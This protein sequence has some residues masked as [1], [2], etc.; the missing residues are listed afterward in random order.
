MLTVLSNTIYDSISYKALSGVRLSLRARIDGKVG[1]L[2]VS[3]QSFDEQLDPP[4]MRR[5][6]KL[7]APQLARAYEA[8]KALLS[9][10]V[11]LSD[12]AS[13]TGV[14][15]SQFSRSFHASVGETFSSA[16]SRLRLE[17][18]MALM[19]QTNMPLSEVALTS[20][21]ADQSTF[22]R[23][24]RRSVGLTPSKWRRLER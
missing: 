10:S 16:L 19:T 3:V 23:L 5:I 2:L 13:I 22:S 20:G 24:F 15:S 6:R 1:T 11:R 7:D 17:S 18:A 21:F 12:I 14:S 9:H 8:I 4:C